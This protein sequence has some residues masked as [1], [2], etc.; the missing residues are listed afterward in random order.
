MA[1]AKP[2]PDPLPAEVA[3]TRAAPRCRSR[4]LVDVH[5][6]GRIERA[7]IADVS[8]SGARIVGPVLRLEPGTPVEIHYAAAKGV[9]PKPL[10]GEF[11]RTTEDGFAIRILSD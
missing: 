11:V 8:P 7:A 1:I 10:R 2:A 9:A 6:A 5:V 4:I 3:S